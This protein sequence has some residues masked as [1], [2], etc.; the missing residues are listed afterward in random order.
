M[1]KEDYKAIASFLELSPEAQELLR[2]FFTK[3]P[4]SRKGEYGR[5]YLA[6]WKLGEYVGKDASTIQDIRYP[7]NEYERGFKELV[8]KGYLKE[9][10]DLHYRYYLVVDGE[11][12]Y[13]A[14]KKEG[15]DDL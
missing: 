1:R 13:P 4:E 8:D 9:I 7:H 2:Q 12:P 15:K 6:T 3:L 5:G 10:E 14:E 11:D